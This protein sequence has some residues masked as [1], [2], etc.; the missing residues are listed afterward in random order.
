MCKRVIDSHKGSHAK[1]K[2]WTSSLQVQHYLSERGIPQEDWLC[3]RANERRWVMSDQSGFYKALFLSVL[4]NT[5]RTEFKALSFPHDRLH[6]NQNTAVLFTLTCDK[7]EEWWLVHLFF[8]SQGSFRKVALVSQTDGVENVFYSDLNR[9]MHLQILQE[10]KEKVFS[11]RL[12]LH[13]CLGFSSNLVCAI[14]SIF[15]CNVC[16]SKLAS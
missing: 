9:K 12:A 16:K 2:Q 15:W 4:F 3:H 14:F 6:R 11:G 10:I 7:L 5:D 1:I 8:L 13:L